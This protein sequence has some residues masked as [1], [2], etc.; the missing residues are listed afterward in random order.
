MKA[1]VLILVGGR[2]LQA[3]LT[4]ASFRLLTAYLAP[5][6]LGGFYLII[7]VST[8]FGMFLL[9]PVGMYINRRL[10][11]WHAS[12][13]VY[14]HFLGYNIFAMAVAAFAFISVWLA[15]FF[16]GVGSQL[17]G[18]TF[19]LVVA[20]YV[21]VLNWNQNFVPALNV[22]GYKSLFVVFNVLTTGL[23]LVLS[24]TFVSFFSSNSI[25][26]MAGL[27]TATGIAAIG[28]EYALRRKLGEDKSGF[29]GG[30]S[31]F[32]KGSVLSIAAFSIPLSGAA[33]FMWA[34]NQSYRVIIE[35]TNGAEFLGY[36]AVGFSIATSVAGIIES[37]VQQIYFP[38]YYKK[39]TVGDKRARQEAL[40]ELTS[41]A[42]PVYL[43]YLFFILGSA[44][45][46]VNFL[47]DSKYKEVFVY[48]RYG[49][50]IEFFRM[51]CNI[52]ASAA[53]SEMNTRILLK[54]YIIGGVSAVVFSFLGAH[55]QRP[56]QLIPLGL[57]LSGIASLA[58]VWFYVERL[59]DI[60]FN[61]SC[62]IEPV[63]LSSLFI[64]LAFFSPHS[65]AASLGLLTISGLYFCFLQY[66]YSRVPASHLNMGPGTGYDSQDTGEGTR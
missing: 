13:N 18:V 25:S 28:A 4:I 16:L 46:L 21:Y 34:Q 26:W 32:C 35:K 14:N 49:A 27:I 45:Y 50:F 55:S 17:S 33:F 24:V 31:Y 1:E 23:G 54:P 60:R 44:E 59:M 52:F 40:M 64:P 48:A 6:D 7:S 51:S 37:L 61:F 53:H 11:A 62:L 3:L 65:A 42:L 15:W 10:F 22:L 41:N 12:K 43:I 39:I 8:L 36:M 9:G 5:A 47:V 56:D 20:C 30:G 66:R 29:F 63:L 2:L 58:A 38:W 57:L 19:A